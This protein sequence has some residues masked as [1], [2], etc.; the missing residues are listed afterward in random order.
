[1]DDFQEVRYIL[2]GNG[3]ESYHPRFAIFGFRYVL[4]K[5]YPGT[6]DPHNFTAV[7]VYSDMEETGGFTCSNPSINQLVSNSIWSQKGNFMEVP[8]DCPTRERAGWT[9]DAQVYARTSS[10]F[11]NVYP[12]FEKWMADLAVEQFQGGSV[13]STV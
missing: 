6:I 11:M 13:P 4:L 2:A 5:N 3:V 7:A 12:F 1:M 8:T 9:G 10:D